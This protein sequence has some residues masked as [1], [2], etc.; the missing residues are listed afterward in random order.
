VAESC[1]LRY[2]HLAHDLIT[3]TAED[4]V[5]LAS[6]SEAASGRGARAWRLTADQ[7]PVLPPRLNPSATHVAWTSTRD[8]SR[9]LGRGAPREAYAV[10]ADGGPARRRTYW[11][12]RF[13]T[14]LGVTIPPHDWAAGRDPQLDTAVRLVLQALEQHPPAA[15][16]CDA[17][18]GRDVTRSLLGTGAAIRRRRRCCGTGCNA[19]KAPSASERSKAREC[20]CWSPIWQGIPLIWRS[21]VCV[22]VE[23]LLLAVCPR[24]GHRWRPV[25]VDQPPRACSPPAPELSTP[26]LSRPAPGQGR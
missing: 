8:G 7:A 17:A 16:G 11:G 12:D 19:S 26:L 2:P 6:L 14:V 22:P 3:F 9:S 24:G 4:D 23:G 10:S 15:G 13:A 25:R 1:Y 5:W 18:A 20:G 21:E